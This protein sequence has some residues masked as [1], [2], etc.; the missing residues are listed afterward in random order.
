MMGHMVE[1]LVIWHQPLTRGYEPA[2]RPAGLYW[3]TCLRQIA[4][5]DPIQEK[6]QFIIPETAERYA[7]GQAY[8]F[9][10]EVV[11]GL[12]SPMVGETEVLGQ[13]RDFCAR[14]EFPHNPWGWFLRRLTG[15]IL[16]AAKSVRHRYL[17]GL[18]CQSYGRIAAQHLA[19]TP[20]IA[21]LGAG[22]LARD[23]VPWLVEQAHVKLFYRT[24]EP[25][26]ALQAKFPQLEIQPFTNFAV[27]WRNASAGLVILAPLPAAE[28]DAWAHQ[29]NHKFTT[30]LDLRS[31]AASD[32][33]TSGGPLVTLAQVFAALS[34]EREKLARQIDAARAE[35][36][37]LA[38][39][40]RQ[41]VFCRP[42]GWEDLCA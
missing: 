4:L 42:F 40:R 31:D 24:P 10:L 36:D 41:D 3:R 1:D 9:L 7:A 28:I 38:Q 18:G 11:C 16:T 29:Q 17:Q 27:D 13:Y 35:I 15:E 6:N 19:G 25:A 12:H 22:R 39:Q 2:Q 14:A 34:S 23:V 8:R 26:R 37:R 33:V 5:L 21:V 20:E 30:T 32:K